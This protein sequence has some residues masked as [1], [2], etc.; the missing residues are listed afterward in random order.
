MAQYVAVAHNTSPFVTAYPWFG[1]GFGAKFANPATLPTGIGYGIAFSPAGDAVAVSHAT[2]PYVS[3]YAW[4]GSGFGTKFANPATLP[5]G[6]GYSVAF[7]AVHTPVAGTDTLTPGLTE[8]SAIQAGVFGGDTATPSL[9][10]A[11]SIAAT[12]SAADALTPGLTELAAT[13]VLLTAGD[14][15]QVSLTEGAAM[16]VVTIGFD[17]LAPG[18][19][20]AAWPDL[21]GMQL[22][23]LTVRL[24]AADGTPIVGATVSALRV[25]PGGGLRTVISTRAVQAA[26]DAAGEAVLYLLPSFGDAYRIVAID[27]AGKALLN[28]AVLLNADADLKDLPPVEGLTWH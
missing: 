26:T 14:T 12:A 17:V 4:S 11:V 5:T 21:A 19:D 25:R 6:D 13:Q 24:T 28:V 9:T 23:A 10:E 2:S 8:G 20:D 16:V 7:V 1:S 22:R 18:I 3:A 15:V 27:A